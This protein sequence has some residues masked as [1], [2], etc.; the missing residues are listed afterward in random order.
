MRAATLLRVY[1][2]SL[3]G[4]PIPATGKS[5]FSARPP[6]SPVAALHVTTCAGARGQPTPQRGIDGA[7]VGMSR[8]NPPQ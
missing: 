2:R 5:T 7:N 6:V 4:G 1:M 3:D 8:E